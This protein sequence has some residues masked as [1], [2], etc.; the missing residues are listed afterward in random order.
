MLLDIIKI[1]SPELHVKHL[2]EVENQLYTEGNVE[3]ALKQYY[4][5]LHVYENI[6]DIRSKTITLGDIA[7]IKT[8]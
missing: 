2:T 7:K 1:A 6:G 8:N 3:K 4:E 5:I